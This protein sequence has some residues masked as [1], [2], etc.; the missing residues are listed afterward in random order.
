MACGESP[1]RVE[2]SQEPIVLAM[3]QTPHIVLTPEVDFK[4]CIV[5]TPRAQP[6]DVDSRGD[7][8]VNVV[9]M[10]STGYRGCQIEQQAQEEQHLTHVCLGNLPP[11]S[12]EDGRRN[13]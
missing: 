2:R 1:V 3:Q 5:P 9:Q 6:I 13:S 7:S 12:T 11:H 8:L 4:I 10:Q